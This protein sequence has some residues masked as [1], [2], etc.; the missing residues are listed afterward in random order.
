MRLFFASMLLTVA[1]TANPVMAGGSPPPPQ[2]QVTVS[3]CNTEWSNSSASQTCRL[4]DTSVSDNRCNF[5][6][7]CSYQTTT[8]D[9][10][11]WSGLRGVAEGEVSSLSNCNGYLTK[12]NC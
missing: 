5:A 10:R 9:D 12:G 2:P 6:V 4:R 7:S 3:D 1:M 8:G 11:R